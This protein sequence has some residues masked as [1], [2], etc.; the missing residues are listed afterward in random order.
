MSKKKEKLADEQVNAEAAGAQ[1]NASA[2]QSASEQ[3]QE[4]TTE[5]KEENPTEE[6]KKQLDEQKDKYLRLSAEFD[7]FRR[8]T[9]KEKMDLTKYAAEDTLKSILPVVDD[10][11]RAMKSIDT[12]TDIEA[13]KEGLRLIHG[14]FIEFLKTKGVTEIEAMGLP[15][16]TDKHEAITLIPAPEENLKGKIV[17]VIEKGYILNEKVIRF[18]KVIIGE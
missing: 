5:V 13:V 6:L 18:S 8:R 7:N 14:K 1:E 11:E 9:L 17:D 3:Q 12:T 15:L 10:F 16:D 4:V 2:E